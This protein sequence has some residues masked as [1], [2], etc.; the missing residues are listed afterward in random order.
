MELS[1]HREVLKRAV[2]KPKI[3]CEKKNHDE[4]RTLSIKNKGNKENKHKKISNENK[5]NSDKECKAIRT[6][7]G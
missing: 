7:K 3:W 4:V 5:N 1:A 6:V 2:I